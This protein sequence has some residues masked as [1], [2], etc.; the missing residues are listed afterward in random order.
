MA[1]QLG[2]V[3][4]TPHGLANAILLPTVMKF[5]GETSYEE[6]R[7]IL[8]QAF[9]TDATKFTKEEVIKTF[10]EKIKDLSEK[11][12]ITQT[13]GDVGGK[14]EDI[15]MLADKAMEDPCKPGNPREVTR[16]DFIKLYEEAM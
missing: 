15:P 16:E 5:N 14:H 4:D 7:E 2:A 10:C 1:H 9:H 13:V 12:G 11:V 6:Y 8:I 3:Y